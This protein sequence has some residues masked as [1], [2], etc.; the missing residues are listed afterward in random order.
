MTKKSF[1]ENFLFFNFL[2]FSDVTKVAD[3]EYD[4]LKLTGLT[5]P[6]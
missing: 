2:T 3:H 4:D 6:Q 5:V 1:F